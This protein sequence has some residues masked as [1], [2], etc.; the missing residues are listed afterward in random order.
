VLYNKYRPAGFSEVCS[1]EHVKKILTNQIL[2][3]R[4]MNAYVFTG[5]TGTGKTTVARILGACVNCST[6]ITVTPDPKDKFASVILSGKCVTDV[7]ERDAASNGGVDD[8]RSLREAA[9]FAPMEMRKKIYIIDECHALTSDSWQALLKIIEE[10]PSY[11]MFVLCTTMINKV[12][13]TIQTRCMVLDF[14]PLP[15][16]DVLS[17]L[18]LIASGEKIEMDDEASRMI[19]SASRGS[20]REALTLLEKAIDIVG[21]GKPICSKDIAGAIGAAPFSKIRDFVNAVIR[22]KFVDA[23]A[24]SSEVVGTGTSAEAFLAEVVKY[25][26]HV[27]VLGAYDLTSQGYSPQELEDIKNTQE[28]MKSSVKEWRTVIP[29]MMYTAQRNAGLTLLNAEPQFQ[30]NCLYLDFK[31]ILKGKEVAK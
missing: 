3:D 5:P 7:V 13:E 30:L 16:Q 18:K 4:L 31:R 25:L 9:K 8:T 1:Q 24:S 15:V 26:H 2:N 17:Q 23:V 27:G 11:L 20:V 19:A 22:Q 29:E 10:P 6:G 21:K 28:M 14:R 12:P